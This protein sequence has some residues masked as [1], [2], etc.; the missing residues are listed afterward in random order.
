MADVDHLLG[1]LVAAEGVDQFRGE[2]QKEVHRQHSISSKRSRLRLRVMDLLKMGT[3][4]TL[5][6]RVNRL[7]PDIFGPI[8]TWAPFGHIVDRTGR[9]VFNWLKRDESN[10][11][12]AGVDQLRVDECLTGFVIR[13]SRAQPVL[14]ATLP[15]RARSFKEL[16][17]FLGLPMRFLDG[18]PV[19]VDWDK[20]RFIVSKTNNLPWVYP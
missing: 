16:M 3:G 12:I 7:C 18:R 13:R 15:A 11:M 6:Q 9:A 14:Y 5:H 2:V 1:M 17:V 8:E 20:R 10:V 4:L 19:G